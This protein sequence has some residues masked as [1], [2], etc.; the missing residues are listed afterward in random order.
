MA[1]PNDPGASSS[2]SRQE[3]L[4]S[5]ANRV[6]CTPVNTDG[7]GIATEVP[8]GV[9]EG[10]KHASTINCDQLTRLEKGVLTD[11][12]GALKPAKLAQLKV[13]LQ[14]ALD[15]EWSV[16]AEYDG[17]RTGLLLTEGDPLRRLP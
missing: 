17:R 11:Y 12:V 8:V 7:A 15:V 14:I 3:L 4:D 6:L 1:I 16:M 13:A 2:V 10:L 5:R 9:D